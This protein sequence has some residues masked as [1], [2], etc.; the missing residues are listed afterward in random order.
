MKLIDR[1]NIVKR[2]RE[3]NRWAKEGREHAMYRQ[4][5]IAAS[6]KDAHWWYEQRMK[7]GVDVPVLLRRHGDIVLLVGLDYV[8]AIEWPSMDYVT[9]KQLCEF[10]QGCHDESRYVYVLTEGQ[11]EDYCVVG[12]TGCKTVAENF[13]KAG[14]FN[15]F[16]RFE[17][18][19]RLSSF[20]KGGK[21]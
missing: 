2:W 13:A 4:L 3:L 19:N 14:R 20:T 6:E 8:N 11:H 1:L 15:D 9:W 12:V 18:N 17:I 10:W 5:E 7:P 21:T 16:N